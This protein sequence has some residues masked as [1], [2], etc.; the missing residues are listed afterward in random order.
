MGSDHEVFMQLALTEAEQALSEGNVAVGSVIVRDGKVVARGRNLANSSRDLTAHAE[1]VAIRELSRSLGLINLEFAVDY[2][3][4]KGYDLY[5]TVEPCPMCGWAICLS[6]IST[7]VFAA[8][9]A[10]VGIR[11]GTYQVEKLLN[12]TETAVRVVPGILRGQS[13]TLRS[14]QPGWRQG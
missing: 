4:L 7:L 5:T 13:I 12:L 10:E 8:R 2:R 9:L 14:S 1:T 11:Y 6:G 3:P